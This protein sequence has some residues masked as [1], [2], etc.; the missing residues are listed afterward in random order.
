MRWVRALVALVAGTALVVGVPLAL[1]GLT[2]APWPDSVPD[3]P[4]AWAA[5][6]EGRL[7]VDVVVRVLAL[8]LWVAW[9]RLVGSLAVEV[10][11]LVRRRPTPRIG[12]LGGSTQRLAAVLVSGISVLAVAP[13]REPAAAADTVPEALIRLLPVDPLDPDA[14]G[15]EPTDTPVP[16]QLGPVPR[17]TWLVRQHDSW[18]GLAERLYGDGARWREL[19][20]LNV[21][22]DAAPGVRLAP[23]TESVEPGWTI[24]LPEVP[25][26]EVVPGDTLSAIA[27]ARLGDAHAW[28]ELWDAN[29]G[30]VLDG[31]RFDDPHLILPGWELRLPVGEPEVVPM[32]EPPSEPVSASVSASVSAP[33]IEPVQVSPG[34]EPPR[35][36]GPVAVTEALPAALDQPAAAPTDEACPV[37]APDTGSRM[38]RG[39]GGAV[40]LATGAVAA[41]E[42]TRRRRWRSAPPHT[43]LPAPSPAA[44]SAESAVRLVDQSELVVRLDLALRAAAAGMARRAV[45]G[46]AP[47]VQLAVAAPTGSIELRFDTPSEPDAPWRPS[48]D[49]WWRLPAGVGLDE[50]AT[51]GRSTAVPCPALVHVGR[52][53]QGEV[54]V[55]VEAL[56]A[57]GIEGDP[58]DTQAIL[59]AIG[60]GLTLSPFS[61]SAALIGVRGEADRWQA[62][63]SWQLVDDAAEAVELAVACTSGLAERLRGIDSTFLARASGGLEAWEPAIVVLPQADV[64]AEHV[65]LVQQLAGTP[66]VG[67]ALVT[68]VP[69]AAPRACLRSVDEEWVLEPFGL[70][71]VPVGLTQDE[72]HAVRTMLDEAE[73]AQATFEPVA[74]ELVPLPDWTLMVRVLGPLDVVDATG[75]PAQFERSKAAEL[76]AWLALHRERATRS[77]ARTALWEIDVQDAT[78]ANV[79]S[80]ARRSLARLAPPPPGE[81]W[82]GRTLTDQLPLHQAVVTDLDVLRAHLDRA[83]LLDGPAGIDE[84]RRGLSL[85]RDVAFSGTGFVWPDASGLTS[86]VVLLVVSAATEMASR[87][88]ELGDVDGVFW[89]TRQGLVVLPGHEELVGL[90]MQAHAAAGDLAGVRSVWE[91]YLRSLAGDAWGETPSPKLVRLRQQLLS[92]TDRGSTPP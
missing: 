2:G 89:A 41:L 70:E 17:P 43:R 7:E 64:A 22:R 42:A 32:V 53:P 59:R 61:L 25:T 62:E 69:G 78:F 45:A 85:V 54:F 15:S 26:V 14:L 21:G 37:V 34:R 55:D 9:A 47:R 13:S 36:P 90:R 51:L 84:L 88:L 8:V 20:E 92:C 86:E 50:L 87:C 80:D 91:E 35:A 16:S 58:H 44:A 11:H 81:E 82:I 48:G 66:A 76:V 60:L 83:R 79:V 56:G 49:R 10:W 38:P 63:R 31:R 30:E 52:A 6:E 12:V 5:V 46:P 74:T 67:I 19:H 3:L 57:L 24:V 75:Q 18:W 71:V 65:P 29:R 77:A 72:V 23:T 68:D 4:A 33:A 28:P 39:L 27:E 73:T 40:L 1:I